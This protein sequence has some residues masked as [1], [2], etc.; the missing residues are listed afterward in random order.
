MA[1]A[2]GSLVKE[3]RL[4]GLVDE[5]DLRDIAA[6]IRGEGAAYARLVRRYQGTVRAQMWRYSR[7]AQAVDELVQDVFVAAFT[8]LRSFRGD[9]PLLH[10]LRAVATRTGYQFWKRQRRERTRQAAARAAL[11]PL[12]ASPA[13]GLLPGEAA[14]LLFKLLAQLNAKDRL[15][16][17]LYY[18]EGCDTNEI[19]ARMGWNATLVRVRMHRACRRLR[20][21][22]VDAGIGRCS[23][24]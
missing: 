19:A 12:D 15:V 5:E 17:T 23:D 3:S 22:M 4:S 21:M 1:P 18:F 9:G 10:W 8:S 24:V 16:L 6:S 14:D 20:G 7:D 13:P 11:G 2:L